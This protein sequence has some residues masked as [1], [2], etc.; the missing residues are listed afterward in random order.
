V[1]Q[2]VN[3]DYGVQP[4]VKTKKQSFVEFMQQTTWFTAMTKSLQRHSEFMR[5]EMGPNEQMEYAFP[6]LPNV[7][8]HEGGPESLTPNDVNPG[9]PHIELPHSACPCCFDVV[10]KECSPKYW[11][12]GRYPLVFNQ[13]YPYSSATHVWSIEGD[14]NP[15]TV[16]NSPPCNH[17]MTYQCAQYHNYYFQFALPPAG[18][19]FESWVK[20]C[21]HITGVCV[22]CVEYTARCTIIDC[23]LEEDYV[24]MTFDDATTPDTIARSNSITITMLNGC[25]NYTW[26]VTGT[27]FTLGT[28]VTVGPTNTLT[29][30][31]SA[32]G[33]ATVTCVDKC[34]TSK[35]AVIR[36]TTGSWGGNVTGCASGMTP[37]A[38]DYF[39]CAPWDCWH[40]TVGKYHQHQTTEGAGG[41]CEGGHEGADCCNGQWNPEFTVEQWCAQWNGQGLRSYGQ[42]IV[43]LSYYTLNDCW[44]TNVNPGCCWA[45]RES[46]ELYYAE[47]GC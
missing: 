23:C 4:N 44:Y 32:C 30:S 36:C 25:G 39:A 21:Y 18:P 13:K 28:A 11:S 29:A 26:T 20:L 31:G 33:P 43:P 10:W 2:Q 37:G 34:G 41:N 5:P 3:Q 42:C 35:T 24:A 14:Y 17:D 19:G 15:L 38:G 9:Q 16:I 8:P 40:A 47:W 46:Y 1:T 27:G 6:D 22:H 7:R 12:G 45:C